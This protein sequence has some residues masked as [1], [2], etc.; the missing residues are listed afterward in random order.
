MQLFLC[1]SKLLSTTFCALKADDCLLQA[2]YKLC[3][4]RL[5]APDTT[6]SYADIPTLVLLT[7]IDEY[8][9]VNLVGDL[10]K[11]FHS[12]KIEAIVKV[13]L[14]TMLSAP[15]LAGYHC[16]HTTILWICL[17]YMPCASGSCIAHV[18]PELFHSV[19]DHHSWHLGILC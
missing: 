14:H 13:S 15:M 9:S 7:K 2:L 11:V 12:T 17:Q 18:H 19:E 10:T 5:H 16:I 1:S 3:L 8:D 6:V 4:Y